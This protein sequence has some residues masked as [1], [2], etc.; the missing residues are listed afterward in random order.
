MKNPERYVGL[1]HTAADG[2]AYGIYIVGL[3]PAKNDFVVM[4]TVL[5]KIRYDEPP[6][7][8]DYF[9]A[10]YRYVLNGTISEPS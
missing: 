3:L 6:R 1:N 9:K 8:L 10:S 2:G 4:N 7:R 5:G